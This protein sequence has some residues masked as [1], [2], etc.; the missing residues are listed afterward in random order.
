MTLA[1]PRRV[2]KCG[3]CTRGITPRRVAVTMAFDKR[4]K[5]LVQQESLNSRPHQTQGL[6]LRNRQQI[7]DPQSASRS[8][9]PPRDHHA[10]DAAR[11]D[12]VRIGLRPRH[13]TGGRIQLPRGAT[14]EGGS[15]RRREFCSTRSTYRLR[16]QPSRPAPSLP[17]QAPN[18][19]GENAGIPRASTPRRASRP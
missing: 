3:M 7:N 19:R 13:K 1:Q 2:W 16:F 6:G 18:E 10:C 14:P 5:R 8:G 11:R 15:R 17:H 9:T 12:R 4:L